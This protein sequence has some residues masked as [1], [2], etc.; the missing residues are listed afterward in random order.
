MISIRLLLF[1][2]FFVV[3]ACKTRFWLRGFCM[4]IRVYAIEIFAVGPWWSE[5][6]SPLTFLRSIIVVLACFK[7]FL[8]IAFL[9]VIFEHLVLNVLDP[10]L[11][12][13]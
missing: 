1:L 7:G 2:E 12:T 3:L 13:A 9:H 10:V 8:I 5:K 6:L 11:L 4:V